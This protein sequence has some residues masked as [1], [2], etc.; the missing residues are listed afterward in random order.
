MVRRATKKQQKKRK[1]KRVMVLAAEGTNKTE[2]TYFNEFNSRQTQYRII[3]ARGNNTD[4]EKIVQDAINSA[5]KE[6][7]DYEYGDRAVAIFDVDF[8]KDKQI[9]N[10]ITI[11][12]ANN[13]E[14]FL[15][16][17]CFEVWFLLHFRFSTKGYSSN[18][19]VIE[20]LKKLWPEY[21]KN[22][23]S[24]NE[25]SSKTLV[26]IDNAK[27]V[28]AYFEKNDSTADVIK[29]NSSTDVDDLV[30]Q[31]LNSEGQDD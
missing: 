19:K 2:K 15:S 30:D 28:K 31:L 18:E 17:P 16:N 6:E 29:C 11:A 21:E 1:T 14:V 7:L 10:A 4:P 13:V 5:K 25:L 3:P 22:K 20:D 23:N 27:K 26:A 24:Y 9:R 8:G 12:N